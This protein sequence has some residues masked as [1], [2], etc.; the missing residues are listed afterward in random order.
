MPAARQV[1][2]P[3]AD[4]ARDLD[5]PM[6]QFDSGEAYIPIKPLCRSLLGTE[7]DSPQRRRILRDPVLSHLSC[8]LPVQTPGGTQ[9]ML[10]LAWLG[11]GRWIDRLSLETVREQYQSRI[12][13]IMW[14]VTFAAYEIVSGQ[15]VLPNLITIVP[16]E[17]IIAAFRDEDARRFL[18]VLHTRVSD[19]E[20]SAR[21]MG[22]L[23]ASL[24]Q[25]AP[26]DGTCPCCKRPLD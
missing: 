4:W 6:L 13:D 5:V 20:M 21:D 2:L 24:A 25:L 19:I 7:D 9:D 1:T 18:R 10:C 8:Y 16:S 26:Q 14:A 11:I 12:L 23:L 15:R 17:R 3:L 22:K